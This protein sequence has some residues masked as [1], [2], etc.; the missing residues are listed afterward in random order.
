MKFLIQKVKNLKIYK[1]EQ[2][3][4]SITNEKFC[5]LIYVGFE[6]GD[7]NKNLKDIVDK[8]ENLPIIDYK[9]KFIKS[10]KEIKPKMVFVSQITL[11]AGFKKNRI[12]FNQSLDFNLAKKIFEDLVFIFKDSGYTIYSAPFGSFLEIESTNL[13]PVN[14]LLND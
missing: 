13:G 7:E 12:N 8:L 11:V 2:V 10:L 4:L 5:Y 6:K 1:N 14:F 9:N 3:R